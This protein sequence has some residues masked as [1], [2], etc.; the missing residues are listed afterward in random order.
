[1]KS[2]FDDSTN[3]T[4]LNGIQIQD[5]LVS[6]NVKRNH[7]IIF[8]YSSKNPLSVFRVRRSIEKLNYQYSEKNFV[9]KLKTIDPLQLV[10]NTSEEEIKPL[11]KRFK[12][13]AAYYSSYE[14]TD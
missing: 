1:M 2:I 4:G 14:G 6:T 7:E 5:E 13:G 3:A 9:D 8:Y 10:N 11:L 12:N